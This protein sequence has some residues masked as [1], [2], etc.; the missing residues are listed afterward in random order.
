MPGIRDSEALVGESDPEECP[1]AVGCVLRGHAV[2][3]PVRHG[4]QHPNS[5]TSGLVAQIPPDLFGRFGAGAKRVVGAG[6][7]F[8]RVTPRGRH[9]KS[10]QGICGTVN[11]RGLLCGLMAKVELRCQYERR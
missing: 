11:R 7:D 6:G 9:G 2:R 1:C 10:P 5:S 8:L 4:E 3:S